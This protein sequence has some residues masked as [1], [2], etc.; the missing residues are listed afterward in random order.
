[1]PPPKS[2]ARQIAIELCR[3]HPEHAARG[4]ARML[5]ER[6][7]GAVTLEAARRMIR[8]CFGSVGK[9]RIKR[10]DVPREKRK[11]GQRK[12]MEWIPPSQSEEWKPIALAGKRL[13]IISDIHVP[14]HDERALR[15]SLVH[16]KASRIDHLLI[17]GD[18]CDF[19][20]ISRF[21]RKPSKRNF[22]NELTQIRA[23]LHGLRK[24]FRNIPITLK[25][26]NHEARWD[27]WLWEHAP[28]IAES[29]EMDLR[30]WLHCEQLDIATVHDLDLMEFGRLP[31]L[32]GHELGK[33][34]AAPVNPARGAY[35][36]AKHT[37]LVGHHH[38]TSSHCESNLYLDEC[39]VWSMGCLCD[40]RPDYHKYGNSNHGFAMAERD[41]AGEFSV[42]NFRISKAGN[43][44]AS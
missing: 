33:G 6:L 41:K 1:M 13:G 22:K 32:H 3:K 36:R 44:R 26:G 27:H 2:E 11:P 35:L 15:A 25:K 28:E 7:N 5:Q 24:E 16:L 10:A 34:I 42:Q 8:E 19:Y 30:T 17:N 29:D 21:Q 14:Y 31:I 4:L 40:L 9:D 12:L 37:I 20:S 43:V 39:Q 38:R 18:L 23:F